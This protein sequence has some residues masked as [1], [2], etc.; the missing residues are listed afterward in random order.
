[1]RAEPDLQ[2]AARLDQEARAFH[3]RSSNARWRG[4]AIYYRFMGLWREETAA[5][6]RRRAS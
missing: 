5:R 6:L 1:M 3:A 4:A 2:L